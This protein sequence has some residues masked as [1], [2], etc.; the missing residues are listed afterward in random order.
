MCPPGIANVS[1]R[2]HISVL[3]KSPTFELVSSRHNLSHKGECALRED[4]FSSFPGGHILQES[5]QA[6][7]AAI[8][9]KDPT[10]RSQH[11]RIVLC[12]ID[13]FLGK[14]QIFTQFCEQFML[15]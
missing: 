1:S 4:T 15:Y 6:A 3:W 11:L 12:Y 7:P 5:L 9:T 2:H 14:V 13:S 10:E 8:L